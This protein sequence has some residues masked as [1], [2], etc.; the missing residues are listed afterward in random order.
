[1]STH[2]SK[3]FA[4]LNVVYPICF[5]LQPSIDHHA[6]LS[7]FFPSGHSAFWGLMIMF[8]ITQWV[9][10]LTA[11][12]TYYAISKLPFFKQYE[13]QKRDINKAETLLLDLANHKYLVSRT[14]VMLIAAA[15]FWYYD[16]QLTA[17]MANQML[18]IPSTSD[19]VLQ[20]IKTIVLIDTY[21]YLFHIMCHTKYFY[22][23]HKEH[24]SVIKPSAITAIWLSIYE[25][26]IFI[27]PISVV[28]IMLF[29]LHFVTIMMASTIVSFHGFYEHSGY[30]LP[31]DPFQLIPFSNRSDHHDDHHHYIKGNYGLYF[32]FWDK[33]FGTEIKH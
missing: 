20:L 12:F 6:I 22:F 31:F 18:N 8:G 15:I 24:H 4:V 16:K 7:Y 17:W 33:V 30:N 14:V 3:L 9:Y 19:N 32:S 5:W 29:D 1:M 27:A 13:I 23:I 10:P 25:E 26:T 2:L 21:Q 11:I 28:P